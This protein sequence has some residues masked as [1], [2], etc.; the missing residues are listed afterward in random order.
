M[1]SHKIKKMCQTNK[2][3][4]RFLKFRRAVIKFKDNKSFDGDSIWCYIF[5]GKKYMKSTTLIKTVNAW[6]KHFNRKDAN[7]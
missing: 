7:E 5:L 2:E 4:L 3:A 6:I 1:T